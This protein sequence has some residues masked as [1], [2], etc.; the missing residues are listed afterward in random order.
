M[1]ILYPESPFWSKIKEQVKN[2]TLFNYHSIFEQTAEN[3]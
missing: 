1:D 3:N 2:T